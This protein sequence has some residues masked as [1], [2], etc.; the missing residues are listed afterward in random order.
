MVQKIS[1]YKP[2]HSG[3]RTFP[4]ALFLLLRPPKV[5]TVTV[6]LSRDFFPLLFAHTHKL[7]I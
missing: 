5:A 1:N 2:L 6:Y 7:N 3:K 4:S